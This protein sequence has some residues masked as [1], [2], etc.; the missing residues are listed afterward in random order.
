M[1]AND[2]NDTH[3]RSSE[4]EAARG[5]G[6]S[7]SI[8]VDYDLPHSA[9]KVWRALTDPALVSVWLMVSDIHPVV[10]H[11]FTFRSQPMPGWDGVVHCEVLEADA[12]R[13]LRYSWRGGSEAARL[14]SVVTW[15]L[16]PSASGGTRLSLEHSGFGPANAFAFDAMN[17]GWRG[18]VADRMA[19]AIAGA[20]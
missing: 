4:G 1:N 6:E 18:K 5:G 14:D 16:E 15:T 13:R 3:R 8:H 17:K 19:E 2:A 11:R 12:P 10:G 20:A 7:R 9:E